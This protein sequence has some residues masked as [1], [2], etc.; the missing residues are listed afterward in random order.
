ML[1]HRRP[2]NRRAQAGFFAKSAPGSYSFALALVL[3][4]F[5]DDDAVTLLAIAAAFYA[6]RVVL[7]P[8]VTADENSPLLFRFFR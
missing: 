1:P 3:S 7:P 6:E 2:R 8:A 5:A 4:A